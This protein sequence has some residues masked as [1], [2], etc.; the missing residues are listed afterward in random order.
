MH[1]RILTGVQNGRV[2]L[3]KSSHIL[4]KNNLFE[5]YLPRWRWLV[6]Q[7]FFFIFWRFS[8]NAFFFSSYIVAYVCTSFSSQERFKK[9]G[10]SAE[11]RQYFA[12]KCAFVKLN[13]HREGHLDANFLNFVLTIYR[14]WLLSQFFDRGIWMHIL[15]LT[16]VQN[17]RRSC[18]KNGHILI[19]NVLLEVNFQDDCPLQANYLFHILVI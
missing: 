3:Q 5:A 11:K 8:V 4:L 19:K 2:S 10:I 17:G 15:I 14:K 6:C 16:G 9:D 12:K 13:F 1:I 18:W 7:L